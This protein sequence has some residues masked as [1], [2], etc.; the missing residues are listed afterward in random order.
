VI[1]HQR[2]KFCLNQTIAGRVLTLYQF[3][4]MA[5]IESESYFRVHC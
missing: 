5:A 4:K 1:L 3:F 2:A